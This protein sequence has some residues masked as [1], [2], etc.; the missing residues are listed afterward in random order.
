MKL[1]KPV[2]LFLGPTCTK[3]L[4]CSSPLHINHEP[5]SVMCYTVNGPVPA[6]KIILRCKSCGINYRYDS[7]GGDIIGGYRSDTHIM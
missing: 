1:G 3:C 2:N 5:T 4:Q 6:Q 7:Y